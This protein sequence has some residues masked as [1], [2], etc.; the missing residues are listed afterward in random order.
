ML[1]VE[2]LKG[3]YSTN[4]RGRNV[5][6]IVSNIKDFIKRFHSQCCPQ[7]VQMLQSLLSLTPLGCLPKRSS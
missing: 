6:T 3:G 4:K 2:G 1:R 5:L 7:N